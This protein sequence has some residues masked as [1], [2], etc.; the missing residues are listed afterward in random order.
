M[1]YNDLQASYLSTEMMAIKGFI[2]VVACTII[3]CQEN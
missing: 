3:K 1:E 2:E